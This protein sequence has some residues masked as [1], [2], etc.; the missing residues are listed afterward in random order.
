MDGWKEG[1]KEGRKEGKE[2]KRE[3]KQVERQIELIHKERNR[4]YKRPHLLIHKCDD[5]KLLANT[6]G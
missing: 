6:T 1:R 3:P 2:S 5:S 4:K